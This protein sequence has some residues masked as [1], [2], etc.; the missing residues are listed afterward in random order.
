MHDETKVLW[1]HF[2]NALLLVI[3]SLALAM[4]FMIGAKF[5]KTF[6]K[7]EFN[8]PSNAKIEAQIINLEQRVRALERALIRKYPERIR[9]KK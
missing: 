4:A 5:Y 8:P 1:K 9:R 6:I 7:P 2:I 3:L